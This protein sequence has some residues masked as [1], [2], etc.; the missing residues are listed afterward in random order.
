[1]N[2]LTKNI[3]VSE[4][5]NPVFIL[6]ACALDLCL[7]NDLEDTFAATPVREKNDYD[8]LCHI[9]HQAVN[10]FKT[11]YLDLQY[12]V[13]TDSRDPTNKIHLNNCAVIGNPKASFTANLPTASQVY[14]TLRQVEK[15]GPDRAGRHTRISIFHKNELTLA[16]SPLL[17]Q[18][19]HFTRKVPIQSKLV[20]FHSV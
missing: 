3:K 14:S 6:A 17:T 8:L 1:M 7:T 10:G 2:F 18:L 15:S 20:V 13:C 16:R 19:L 5:N 9:I 11:V 4:K 12:M